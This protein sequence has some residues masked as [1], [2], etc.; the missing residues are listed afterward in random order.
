MFRKKVLPLSQ[1]LREVMRKDGLETPLNEKRVIDLWD[2][3]AGPMAARYTTEKFIRNQTLFV[4]I[5]NP[6]LKADLMMRRTEL[7]VLLNQKVG[8][9]VISE[10]KIY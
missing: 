3:V 8:A 2:Q 1:I 4:K 10:I 7:Q 9:F 5:I 6:S